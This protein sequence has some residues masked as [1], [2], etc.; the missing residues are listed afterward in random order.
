MISDNPQ[1]A[2]TV[3]SPKGG[4]TWQNGA[5]QT[6]RWQ[7]NTPYPTN[8]SSPMMPTYDV[9]LVSSGG[10][11]NYPYAC[12]NIA[13]APQ[14]IAKNVIDESYK[15]NVGTTMSGNI[16]TA[17]GAYKIQVCI[18]GAFASCG[19]SSSSFSISSPTVPTTNHSPVINS[20]TGPT[21]LTVGQSGTY[22][23]SAM[24]PDGNTINYGFF[25]GDGTTSSS[26]NQTS[27]GSA[28]MS[29]TFNSPGTFTITVGVSDAQYNVTKQITV[30]VSANA[31]ATTVYVDKSNRFKFSYPAGVT[32]ADASSG[33]ITRYISINMG[34]KYNL[35]FSLQ[36]MADNYSSY[37]VLSTK[38]ISI[39]GQQATERVFTSS[40]GSLVTL[41]IEVKRYTFTDGSTRS[42]SFIMNFDTVDAANATASKIE[43]IAQT[44]EYLSS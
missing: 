42:D 2:I 9:W 11:C 3:L 18:A 12:S 38:N 35:Y 33:S 20:L 34:L 21:S 41:Q 5:T 10:N 1:S 14:A 22:A 44:L 19:T 31:Q 28:S 6:I 16:G 40:S 13:I 23:A 37:T 29:H 43:S 25:W 24:D 39:A 30:T 7:M 36:A 17:G 15:W 32:V 26:P 27:N 8:G 4:E